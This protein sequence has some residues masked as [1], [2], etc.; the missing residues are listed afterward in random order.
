MAQW[1][2][3]GLHPHPAHRRTSI[4]KRGAYDKATVHAILDEGFDGRLSLAPFGLVKSVAPGSLELAPEAASQPRQ[5][6]NA[7]ASRCTKSDAR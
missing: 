7:P 1:H 3:Y 6:R 5:V 4:E 2:S